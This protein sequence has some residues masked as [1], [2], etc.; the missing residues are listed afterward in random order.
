MWV[1][2]LASFSWFVESDVHTLRV[3]KFGNV[4][5]LTVD[6]TERSILITATEICSERVPDVVG[7]AV[8]DLVV[9]VGYENAKAQLSSTL[10]NPELADGGWVAERAAR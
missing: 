7:K 8:T 10:A 5:S 4:T 6:A 2:R 9:G 1:L 3:S